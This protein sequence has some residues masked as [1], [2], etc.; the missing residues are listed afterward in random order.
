MFLIHKQK[1]HATEKTVITKSSYN[2]H[3]APLF[4]KLYI[5]PLDKVII[6]ANLSFMH[7][8][9]YEYA[10]SS[11]TGTWQTQ[12][13]RNPDL[14]LRNAR[15]F[16]T[17]FPRIKLFK[18]LPIYSLPNTWNSYDIT[19]YFAKRTTFSIVIKELLHTMPSHRV[20]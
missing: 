17:P 3:Y 6:Q 2:A 10:P 9:Y 13:Q 1:L 5:L 11:F 18:K 8:L 20:K 4:A 19:H 12:A 16:Y 7:S 14:N 15:D